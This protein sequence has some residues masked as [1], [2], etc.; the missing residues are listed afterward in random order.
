MTDITN[1]SVMGASDPPT[2]EID[3]MIDAL[4]YPSGDWQYRHMRAEAL[5]YLLEHADVAHPRLLEMLE[6]DYPSALLIDSIWRFGRAESVPVLEKLL[7][8]STD[9]TSVAAGHALG[10][11]PH[12]EAR[13]ALERALRDSN[14]Q[15]VASAVAGLVLRADDHSCEALKAA[16]H[17]FDEELQSRSEIRNRII[18]AIDAICHKAPGNDQ[19]AGR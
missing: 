3:S 11:H 2:K 6:G 9:I 1:H 13:D 8:E 12:I 7:H 19:L 17:H 15:V 4:L 14:D 5:G 18:A 10:N 16:L